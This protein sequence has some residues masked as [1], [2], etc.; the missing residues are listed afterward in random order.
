MRAKTHCQPVERRSRAQFWCQKQKHT[1]PLPP[2]TRRGA[3]VWEAVAPAYCSWKECALLQQLHS[4]RCL[5]VH[6]AGTAGPTPRKQMLHAAC[7]RKRAK[8]PTK[9]QPHTVMTRH[10]TSILQLQ[11]SSLADSK[12][13][14]CP[15]NSA[16]I[17]QHSEARH[18]QRTTGCQMLHK[19]MGCWNPQHMD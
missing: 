19:T 4:R 7:A 3:A 10:S 18:E 9:K 14:T 2:G 13:G 11:Q 15:Q 17:E 8:G 16:V 12:L 6:K 5:A 1:L